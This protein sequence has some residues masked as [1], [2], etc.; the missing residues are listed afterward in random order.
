MI[1]VQS[2]PFDPHGEAAAFSAGSTEAGALATFTG[3]VRNSAHAHQDKGGE[4]TAL[5]LEHYPGF[6]EAKIAEIEA[7]ARKRFDVIDL[8]IIHRYGRMAPGE[9][10]VFVGALSKHRRE[11][12]QAVD[13]LMD[14]L[15]TD[16]PF[17]KKEL[18]TDGA[19]EWIEPRSDDRDARAR[20]DPDKTSEGVKR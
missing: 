7:E 10:I 12:L 13:F 9:A 5:E 17:W 8:V 1:R 6:T 3:S 11:A 18:R 19:P 20:W 14:Q 15:K 2:A 16:A 4:I